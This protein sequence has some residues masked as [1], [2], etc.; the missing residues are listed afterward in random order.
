METTPRTPGPL[1]RAFVWTGGALFVVSL[2]Y[3]GLTYVVTFATPVQAS[4]VAG[5][6]AIDVLLFSAFALHHS[7][8]ARERARARIGAAVGPELERAVYVWIAS[9]MLIAVC[10]LWQA[11]PGVA[12]RVTGGAAVVFYGLQI[13]GA[14]ISVWS[15]AAIDALELA[16]IRQLRASPEPTE[17]RTTGP[18]GWVRHPIYFGWFLMVFATPVM[19]ASRLAFALVSSVYLIIAIPFEE[20]SLLI[21]SKGAY[22]RYMHAVRWKLIPGIF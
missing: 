7:V 13:A 12:W 18:Y 20:R 2:I 8:F 4:D 16:G 3:T 14:V 1:A 22:D 19:T 9:L 6:L 10:A 11:V 21:A 5:P 17:F 15:A